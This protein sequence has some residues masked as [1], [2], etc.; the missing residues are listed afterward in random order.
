[1]TLSELQQCVAVIHMRMFTLTMTLQ[2]S[3]YIYIIV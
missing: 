1:M 2:T 3:K